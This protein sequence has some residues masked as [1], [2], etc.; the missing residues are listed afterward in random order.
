MGN[1]G[2]KG[3]A[4]ATVAPVATA[5]PVAAPV[6]TATAVV[7]A[8]V[9]V[10]AALFGAVATLNRLHARG[11]AMCSYKVAGTPGIAFMPCHW[12]VGNVPPAT[13]AFTAALPQ[14]GTALTL[15]GSIVGGTRA[16]YK[17]AGVSGTLTVHGNLLPTP[18]PATLAVNVALVA[19]TVK[20]SKATSAVVAATT[21]AV[22]ATAGTLPAVATPAAQAA[23]AAKLVAPLVG[24]AGGKLA[25]KAT[26]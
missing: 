2:N 6:V 10:V 18:Y 22:A 21:V 17:L 4:T 13:L 3:K 12:F 11:V 26:A 9:A 20:P 5:A 25:G 24:N 15:A 1:K 23:V 8:V 19:A 7:N 14:G 16:V